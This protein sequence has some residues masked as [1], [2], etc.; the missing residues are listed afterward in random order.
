MITKSKREIFR[1]LLSR[2]E[3]IQHKGKIKHIQEKYRSQKAVTSKLILDIQTLICVK[4]ELWCK[5]Q[6]NYQLELLQDLIFESNRHL[7][8]LWYI[9]ISVMEKLF[10]QLDL[11]IHTFQINH[12]QNEVD[13]SQ[14][15]IYKLLHVRKITGE[16]ISRI[17]KI[18]EAHY[19]GQVCGLI[20]VNLV[21]R[22]GP[23]FAEK[24]HKCVNKGVGKSN[25]CNFGHSEISF[26]RDL[27]IVPRAFIEVNC[28]Q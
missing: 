27:C 13:D 18:N 10:H 5:K 26:L 1:P 6:Y 16:E 2:S 23:S 21:S 9:F 22:C 17:Y 24:E 20:S 7:E 11:P 19:H 12:S 25:V 28:I 8:C 14:N 4:Q 15:E 3:H